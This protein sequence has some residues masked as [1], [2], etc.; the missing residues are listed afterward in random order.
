MKFTSFHGDG[1]DISLCMKSSMSNN[2]KT[3][4][5]YRWKDMCSQ[6]I[7]FFFSFQSL[8]LGDFVLLISNPNEGCKLL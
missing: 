3:H 4:F 1:R 5:S 2:N 7:G 8:A 6:D